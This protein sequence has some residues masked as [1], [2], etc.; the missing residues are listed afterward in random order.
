VSIESLFGSRLATIVACEA[1]VELAG[2]KRYT[3]LDRGSYEYID[4]VA[5]PPIVVE[6]A[7]QLA[8]RALT[9]VESRALRLV[10]GDY[11]L[12]H[13][14]R[15]YDDHPIE[16]VLDVSPRAVPC[17]VDYRR[18]GQVFF[19]MPCEPGTL[20]AVERGPT[21]TRNH[22]YVSK[23]HAGAEVLRIIALLR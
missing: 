3:L 9:I 15:I 10:P 5:V 19:R 11:V 14:D 1:R 18:R 13:H 16:T 20:A 12:A 8:G 6:R 2:W 17:A 23:L 22:T 7:S 21:V 4:D